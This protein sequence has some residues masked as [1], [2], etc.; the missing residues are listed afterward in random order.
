VQTGQPSVAN[1]HFIVHLITKSLNHLHGV[2]QE[3]ICYCALIPDGY[4]DTQIIHNQIHNFNENIH[5]RLRQPP[6][7]RKYALHSL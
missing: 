5:L 1:I 6:A 3:G 2:E 4:T 7:F